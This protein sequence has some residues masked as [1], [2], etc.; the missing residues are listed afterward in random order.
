MLCR[1]LESCVPRTCTGPRWMTVGFSHGPGLILNLSPRCLWL[2]GGTEMI[3]SFSQS[4]SC[5]DTFPR[6]FLVFGSLFFGVKCN[7]GLACQSCTFLLHFAHLCL[8]C[9]R[10]G[11]GKN[12]SSSFLRASECG[13]CLPVTSGFASGGGAC[14]PADWCTNNFGHVMACFADEQ[15]RVS[16]SCLWM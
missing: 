1:C 13:P 2:L 6:C 9:E 7:A 11:M 16:V 4:F 8:V 15:T 5:T 10:L 12:G 3:L 14:L